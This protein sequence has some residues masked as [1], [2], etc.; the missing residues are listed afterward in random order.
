MPEGYETANAPQRGRTPIWSSRRYKSLS[1]FFILLC[2]KLENMDSEVSFEITGVDFFL[3]A[4]KFFE[5]FL[6]G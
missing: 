2:R 3:V 5:R 6:L 4:F 1:N